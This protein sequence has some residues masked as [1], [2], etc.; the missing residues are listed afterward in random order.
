MNFIRNSLAFIG[1]LALVAGAVIYFKYGNMLTQMSSMAAEQAALPLHG[2]N[3][4]R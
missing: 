3:K 1:L 2:I 4:Y